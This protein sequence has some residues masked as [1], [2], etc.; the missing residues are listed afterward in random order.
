MCAIFDPSGPKRSHIN[1]VQKYEFLC[2][3]FLCEVHLVKIFMREK[4]INWQFD[5]HRVL[6]LICDNVEKTK[7]Q[8]ALISEPH[9]KACCPSLHPLDENQLHLNL[10][11][12][13]KKYLII[14]PSFAQVH[15]PATKLY[16]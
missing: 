11:R 5:S 4:C 2:I 10:Q 7:A 9:C 6:A 8:Y 1:W 14:Y 3:K 15:F 16:M 12:S 13:I